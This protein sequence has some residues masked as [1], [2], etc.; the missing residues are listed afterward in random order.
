MDG[1][2]GLE[3]QWLHTSPCC[4][5]HSRTGKMSA[6]ASFKAW[7][8]IPLNPWEHPSR[9]HACGRLW[10]TICKVMDFISILGI[11]RGRLADRGKVTVTPPSTGWTYDYFT[12]NSCHALQQP[13]LPALKPEWCKV[14]LT[15]MFQ[16]DQESCDKLRTHSHFHFIPHQLQ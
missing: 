3:L 7:E 9:Q 14:S 16:P 8:I 12:F 4:L 10:F 1:S 5:P 15:Q 13:L 6:L 2:L 11:N